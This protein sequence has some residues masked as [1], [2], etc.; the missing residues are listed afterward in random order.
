MLQHKFIFLFIFQSFLTLATRPFT[1]DTMQ[2]TVSNNGTS[3]LLEFVPDSLVLS[4]KDQY[5]NFTSSYLEVSLA[6]CSLLLS[7]RQEILENPLPRVPETPIHKGT[8]E[9]R[10]EVL[11][12]VGAQDTDTMGY[13]VSDLEDIEFS[14]E[15][16]EVD[17]DSVY[18]PGIVTIFL[19]QHLTIHRWRDGDGYQM[20]TPL[21]W[22]NSKNRRIILFL[23]QHLSLSDPQNPPACREVAL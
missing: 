4:V 19:Q 16:P 21:C 13:E 20:K 3:W 6:S 8:F 15:N 11:S 2:N 17:M 23:H 14:W 10:G 18:G 7:Q 22:V 5:K 12:S 9:M 1:T